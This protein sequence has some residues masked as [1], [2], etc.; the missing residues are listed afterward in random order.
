[1][2]FLKHCL[3]KGKDYVMYIDESLYLEFSTS[4]WWINSGVTV[5]VA[6][7]L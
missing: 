3:Q 5:H 1:M 4:A 7:S 2:E 6:N